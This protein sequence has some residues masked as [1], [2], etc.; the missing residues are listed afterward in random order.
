MSSEKVLS[1]LRASLAAR[2]G[3]LLPLGQAFK[4][5]NIDNSGY[6][7]WEAFCGALRSCGLTPSPQ[8][9]RLLFLECDK[10][11]NNKISMQEFIDALKVLLIYK[12]ICTIYMMLLH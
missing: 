7:D 9:V 8:D 11:G 2:G 1:R 6:L 5:F 3:G 12:Y 10:D 4:E